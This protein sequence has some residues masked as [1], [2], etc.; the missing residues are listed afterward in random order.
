MKP[1]DGQAQTAFHATLGIAYGCSIVLVGLNSYL[2]YALTQP[3][4]PSFP[5]PSTISTPIILAALHLVG[6]WIAF[7]V[8]HTKRTNPIKFYVWVAVCD[9]L[10]FEAYTYTAV[11]TFGTVNGN[12]IVCSSLGATGSNGLVGELLT[13]SQSSRAGFGV[14]NLMRMDTGTCN[15]L[16]ASWAFLVLG[17]IFNLLAALAA[18]MNRNNSPRRAPRY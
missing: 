8:Y 18:Y 12:G 10:L 1:S 15:I 9:F 5:I 16:K 11:G 3:A 13:V 7:F 6:A 4:N 2:V 17:G 14:V